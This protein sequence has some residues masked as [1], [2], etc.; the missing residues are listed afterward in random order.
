MGHREI[1]RLRQKCFSFGK[2]L[3]ACGREFCFS[4][5]VGDSFEMSLGTGDRRARPKCNR[6]RNPSYF[7]RQR[8]RR[9]AFL[10]KRDLAGGNLVGG[11]LGIGAETVENIQDGEGGGEAGEGILEGDEPQE[12]TLKNIYDLLS[13]LSDTNN[14][15]SEHLSWQE[16]HKDSGMTANLPETNDA[17]EEE[18]GS[19]DENDLL[20]RFSS[21]GRS[22]KTFQ[23]DL[24]TADQRVKSAKKVSSPLRKRRKKRR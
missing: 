9:E 16:S 20:V 6:K 12:V 11:V 24:T 13:E 7:R 22:L 5:K 3:L 17:D 10:Q 15:I 21:L 18:Q 8:R 4:L 23:R 1:G 2:M 19:N 14:H